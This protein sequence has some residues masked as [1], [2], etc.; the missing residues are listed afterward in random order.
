MASS[1]V[2]ARRKRVAAA[3]H[4]RVACLRFNVAFAEL[5][6]VDEH[7]QREIRRIQAD[8]VNVIGNLSPAA[9]EAREQDEAGIQ[10]ETLTEDILRAGER[11]G[12]FRIVGQEPSGEPLWDLT[13]KGV[14]ELLTPEDRERWR[15]T[16]SSDAVL[17]LRERLEETRD[18]R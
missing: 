18:A 6:G 16:R 10:Y 15:T 1:E 14:E 9:A 13:E 12:H 11:K 17:L 7:M 8:V 4:L 2:Y 5:A 3:Q